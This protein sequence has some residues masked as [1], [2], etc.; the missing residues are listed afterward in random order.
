MAKQRKTSKNADFLFATGQSDMK[1][2]LH[3]VGIVVVGVGA[4]LLIAQP[5]LSAIGVKPLMK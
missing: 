3:K 5:L 1:E 2:Y 4:Y